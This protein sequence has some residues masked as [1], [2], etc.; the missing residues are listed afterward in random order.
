M[1]TVLDSS[2]IIAALK[3]E[4]GGDLVEQYVSSGLVSTA[5]VAEVYS[6]A[7]RA[8]KPVELVHTFLAYQ[9]LE[10][11]DLSREQAMVAGKLTTLTRSAGLS[12]GDRSCLALALERNCAVLTADRPW[13]QFAE[14][15]GIEIKTIR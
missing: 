2:V 11:V 4:P 6:Y 10:I 14:P 15:L 1:T 5:N 12:L 13:I 3:D 8:G 7:A 9:G